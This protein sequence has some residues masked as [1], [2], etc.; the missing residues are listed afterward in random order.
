MPEK[1]LNLLEL[2]DGE[3]DDVEL[4]REPTNPHDHLAIKVYLFGIFVGYIPRREMREL[5]RIIQKE[6]IIIKAT[7]M[8]GFPIDENEFDF[9]LFIKIYSK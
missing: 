1:A 5:R 9:A 6:N 2:N 4:M 8:V 3:T 7:A